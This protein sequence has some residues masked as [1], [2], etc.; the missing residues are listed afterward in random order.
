MKE[1]EL[2]EAPGKA[3]VSGGLVFSNGKS[4]SPLVFLAGNEGCIYNDEM[5]PQLLMV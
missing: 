3:G 4:L 5:P 1:D 2:C